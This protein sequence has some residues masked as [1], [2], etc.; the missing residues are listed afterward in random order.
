MSSWDKTKGALEHL[1]K[2]AHI[3]DRVINGMMPAFN[4]T[5]KSF[6]LSRITG[7]S[8]TFGKIP[9]NITL[10]GDNMI[11]DNIEQSSQAR[12]A[13]EGKQVIILQIIL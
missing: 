9:T 8:F 12:M 6:K 1:L 7:N 13:N 5:N 2:E 4:A 3:T 10:E 11:F